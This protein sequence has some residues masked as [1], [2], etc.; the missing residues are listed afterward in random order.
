[1]FRGVDHVGVG[2]ADMQEAIEFY[3]DKLGF[4]KVLFDYSGSL[5]GLERVTGRAATRARVVML[6]SEFVSPLGQ[7]A[8]KLVQLLEPAKYPP[9]PEGLAWG[10]VGISEVCLN[11]S[12][13]EKVFRY[14]V[15]ELKCPPIMEPVVAPLPPFGTTAEFSYVVDPYGGKVELI[16]WSDI[17]KGLPCEPRL[18][19]VNHVAFGVRDMQRTKQFYSKFGFNDLMFDYDG[20]FAPMESW[21]VSSPPKQ[22]IVM[23]TSWIGAG[24]EPVQHDP[25][26]ADLRGEWGHGGPMEFAVG[27]NNLDQAYEDLRRLGV[28]FHSPPQT[29]DVGCGEWRYVYLSDPDDLYVSLVEARY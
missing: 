1:M 19:G 12:G 25:P 11:T 2:V 27:V 26:S 15:E 29:I 13:H 28:E 4:R 9:L 20:Y 17:W 23:V 14:L 21:Y 5:P 18:E 24:I 6:R 7:G 8:I 3:G 22:H 10:E 16:E